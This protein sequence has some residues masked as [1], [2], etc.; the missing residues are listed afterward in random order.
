MNFDEDA[1]AEGPHVWNILWPDKPTRQTP[2]LT[3]RPVRRA[4]HTCTQ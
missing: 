4:Q 2:L 3:R 1:P